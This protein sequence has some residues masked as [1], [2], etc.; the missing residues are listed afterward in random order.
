M[1]NECCCKCGREVCLC[2]A[3]R[4]YALFIGAALAVLVLDQLSKFWIS[5]WSGLEFRAYPPDGG[6]VVI[7]GFFSIVYN[8]NTGAAWGMFAGHRAVLAI[9]G[10]GAVAAIILLR[11][12]LEL[13]KRPMQLVFGL[14]LGGILGNLID[15]VASG[16]V[17]DFLDFTFGSYRWPTFNV[18]D[19]AMCVAVAVYIIYTLFFHKETTSSEDIKKADPSDK[20][21]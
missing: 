8:T 21:R 3:V 9:L 7:P 1:N 16:R 10:I 20:Q 4:R 12:K 5:H 11:H 6:H 19:S 18:A 17:T 13:E 14:M 2:K 15:R